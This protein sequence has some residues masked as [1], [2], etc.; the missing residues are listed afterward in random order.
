MKRIKILYTIP[1]FDT[2]GSGKALLKIAQRLDPSRFEPH[3]CC[4]HDRGSFF[5]VVKQSGIPVHIHP[6]TSTMSSRIQ[7]LS[8]S[9]K[10][11]RF[12]KSLG[13]DLI[14]SFHYSADYSE[15]LAAR[16]ARIKW[17]Y[18]KKNMNWGGGSANAWKLRTFLAN[19]ILAQNTDMMK[20]FFPH[21]KRVALV[22]RG[23]DTTEFRPS[24]KETRLFREFQLP[25]HARI[26][27][28]VA[29]LVPVKGVET[30]LE[31]FAS[32]K[33]EFP[34]ILFI[35]GDCQSEYAQQLIKQAE[36]IDGNRIIFTGKRPDVS[37]FHSI[38]DIFVL[39]TLNQGRQ[40]GSPVS[41]L[42]AMAAGT[43]VLAG[44]VAGIRDQLSQIPDHLF[45]PGNSRALTRKIRKV[46]DMDKTAY[47]KTTD[48]QRKIIQEN[49][50]IE[51]EVSRH[52]N[53]YTDILTRT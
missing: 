7:T 2:A 14:H 22:P 51:Q 28:C 37:A 24:P 34:V 17:V 19:G 1:N 23:V 29:N 9:W 12:F 52:E 16:M 49:H 44:N 26:I 27:L 13:V 45:E 11:S 6:F 43:C 41:L 33:D 31:A 32:L 47:Q 18:T 50:T 42:E 20:L 39:P 3:I 48:L 21:T 10:I 46:L 4:F 36:A 40:E 15:A 35:V 8:D 53:F 38:A 30:L 5:Q 25:E